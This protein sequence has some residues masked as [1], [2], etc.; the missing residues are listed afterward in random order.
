MQIYY[1]TNSTVRYITRRNENMYRHKG[2]YMSVC[3]RIIH[4][5]QKV[6]AVQVSIT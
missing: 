2:L 6:E 4:N 3:S 1:M 5:I